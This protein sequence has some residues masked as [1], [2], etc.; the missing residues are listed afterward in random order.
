MFDEAA[1]PE[2]GSGRI[3]KW[4]IRVGIA[5][6]FVLFGFDKFPSGPGTMWV[7][8]YEQ[9]GVGQWFRYLTGVVEVVGGA[10][11]LVPIVWVERAGLAMLLATMVVASAIHVVVM[12]HPENAIITG[13]I[14]LGLAA[15]LWRTWQR[16]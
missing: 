12:H 9:I 10:M 4:M 5:L 16:G 8:F 6:A 7:A 2:Q 1:A 13:V 11:V 14:G 15:A 3:G